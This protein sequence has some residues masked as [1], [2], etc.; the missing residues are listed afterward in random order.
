MHPGTLAHVGFRPGPA[1][2]KRR[3]LVVEDEYFLADDIACA[4]VRL[5]AEAVG[6]VPT[7]AAALACLEGGGRIDACVLD[8]NLRGEMAFAVADALLA[9][10]VPFMFATGYDGA[11]VPAAYGHIRRWEKPFHADRLARALQ[12]LMDED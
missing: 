6:P 12:G 3:V 2:P 9:R 7:R 5:G 10:G 11:L 1:A 8:I 4:L